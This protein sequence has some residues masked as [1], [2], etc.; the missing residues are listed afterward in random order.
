MRCTA[1]AFIMASVRADD[2]WTELFWMEYPPSDALDQRALAVQLAVRGFDME[3]NIDPGD[4]QVVTP[5]TTSPMAATRVAIRTTVMHERRRFVATTI[6]LQRLDWPGT[7]HELERDRDLGT[8]DIKELLRGSAVRFV[9]V[10]VGRPIAW[11]DSSRA[12]DV[13]KLEV[14]PHLVEPDGPIDI[15]RIPGGYGYIASLWTGDGGDIPSAVVLE[16]YH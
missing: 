14:R 7:P 10:D 13:W 3:R 9:V 16:K 12:F 4:V 1:A 2:E 15:S 5:R 8:G 11:I 6:P